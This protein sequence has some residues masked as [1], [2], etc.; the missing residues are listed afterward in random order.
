[1]TDSDIQTCDHC[2]YHGP[3][4]RDHKEEQGWIIE[5][6]VCPECGYAQQERKVLKPSPREG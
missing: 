3:M 1:M 6:S 5:R 2:H 4:V